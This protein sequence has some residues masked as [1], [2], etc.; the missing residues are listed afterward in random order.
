MA[1]TDGTKESLRRKS[2]GELGELIAIKT[3]VDR[4]FTEVANLNDRKVNYPFADLYAEKG[5]TKYVI[6]IK[7]RNKNQQDGKLNAFYNLG[8]NARAMA[9]SAETEYGAV[10]YWMAIQFDARVYSVYFGSLSELNGKKAIPI[11][12]CEEGVIGECLEKDKRHYFD[13]GYF[14]NTSESAT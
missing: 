1:S 5:K 9:E 11:R 4:S 8:F 3:L 14:G 13:F 7:A 12:K 2:L 10:A 6:S